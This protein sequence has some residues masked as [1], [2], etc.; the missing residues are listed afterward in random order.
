[1]QLKTT[2]KLG[3]AIT[4]LGL[5]ATCFA[6]VFKQELINTLRLGTQIY[7]INIP[8]GVFLFEKGETGKPF[9]ITGAVGMRSHR[10]KATL[11]PRT[12][13][14]DPIEWEINELQKGYPQRFAWTF[15]LPAE[16]QLMY[17]K[18]LRWEKTRMLD[19]ILVRPA[20]LFIVAG[21]SNASG[22][23]VHVSIS[24]TDNVYFGELSD[25]GIEWRPG[26]DPGILHGEGSVWPLVGHALQ[27]QH[28]F[29]VGFIN[30]AVGGTNLGDWQPGSVF[31]NRLVEA[32][33]QLQPIGLTAVLWHQ[34]ESDHGS[35]Q[36]E[37]QIGL[38]TIIDSSRRDSNR[39]QMPWLVSIASL[40]EQ[41]ISEA[42]RSG[43][44]E[45][46][47]PSKF[48][49]PGP[50]TDTIGTEFRDEDYEVHFTRE[51]NLLAAELWLE[52]L[53]AFF[54]TTGDQN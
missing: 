13:D 29:A 46:I 17:L 14:Y 26:H 36:E 11:I 43:Q 31:Y 7:D 33:I 52:A 44:A 5:I 30:V 27:E 12:T 22:K 53:D 19:P 4:V 2:I 35:T 20:L 38:Q 25:K 47:D 34:G 3:A 40:S 39:P 51:A 9:E 1:M 24:P 10:V 8:N 54:E 15:K 6:L 23:S 41:R 45:T 37:Y 16:P 32:L 42:I 28:G 49:F 21:Q 18:S 50:D 48:I